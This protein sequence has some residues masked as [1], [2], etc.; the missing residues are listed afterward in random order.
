MLLVY[1]KKMV[2]LTLFLYANSFCSSDSSSLIGR[3]LKRQ[4]SYRQERQ[5]EHEDE[6]Q[7]RELV[8]LSYHSIDF[9]HSLTKMSCLETSG[10]HFCNHGIKSHITRKVFTVI[11]KQ[12]DK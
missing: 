11:N 7:E 5:D 6:E 1:D 12:T 3:S 10:E 8:V 9:I 2:H 4:L